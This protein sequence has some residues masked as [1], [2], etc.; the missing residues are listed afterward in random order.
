MLNRG[1]IQGEPPL[2][3]IWREQTAFRW[4]Q[5]VTVKHG[6]QTILGLGGEPHHFGAVSDQSTV[7]ADL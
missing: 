4:Q 5:V 1:D 2:A 6:V 3:R 7:I